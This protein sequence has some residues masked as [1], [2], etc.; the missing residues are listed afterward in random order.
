MFVSNIQWIGYSTT[1]KLGTNMSIK[2]YKITI[3]YIH[4][5]MNA[6]MTVY[7]YSHRYIW[8]HE[9]GATLKRDG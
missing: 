7:P 5:Y 3:Q 2:I 6:W 8:T 9:E 4:M 1:L